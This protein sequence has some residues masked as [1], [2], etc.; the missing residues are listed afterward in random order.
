MLPTILSR[1]RRFDL[2]PIPQEELAGYVAA[3][4]SGVSPESAGEAAYLAAGRYVDAVALALD[5]GWSAAVQSL[6]GAFTAAGRIDEALQELA[7]FELRLLV[8]AAAG[9]GG[10]VEEEL[11]GLAPT[12]RNELRRQALIGGIDR[13]A[14]WALRGGRP[15]AGFGARLSRLKARINQNVDPGLAI[16]AFSGSQ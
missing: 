2:V 16:A 13:A 5:P 7:G 11:A 1:A 3:D 15:A 8:N 12:R 6:A 4:C 9:D 14:W 10:E